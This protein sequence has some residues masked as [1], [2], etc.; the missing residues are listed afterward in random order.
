MI[1]EMNEIVKA[2]CN[3]I[4]KCF[5]KLI[6]K[7]WKVT[8]L[9]GGMSTILLLSYWIFFNGGHYENHFK[10]FVISSSCFFIQK[11]FTFP[12]FFY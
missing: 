2:H 5:Q 11:N 9:S 4:M 8:Y 6:M 12:M 10:N 3:K 7:I 1:K